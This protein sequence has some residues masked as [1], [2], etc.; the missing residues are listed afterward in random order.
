MRVSRL[1]RDLAIDSISRWGQPRRTDWEWTFGRTEFVQLDYKEHM[2]G[3]GIRQKLEISGALL[4][5]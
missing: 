5:E 4:V 3:Y 1:W 2:A